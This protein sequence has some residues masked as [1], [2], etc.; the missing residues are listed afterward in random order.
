MPGKKVALNFSNGTI[1]RGAD[2]GL[3]DRV[4]AKWLFL[5]NKTAFSISCHSSETK[6]RL[7]LEHVVDCL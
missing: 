7:Q 1:K 6:I 5:R 4:I 2:G 3:D